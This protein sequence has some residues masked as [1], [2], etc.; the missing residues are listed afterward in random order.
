MKQIRTPSLIVATLALLFSAM[1]AAPAPDMRQWKAGAA[2]VDIT[3]EKPVLMAGY[4]TRTTPSENVMQKLYAKA[5]AM[6]DM[7]GARV[8]WVTLDLIGTPRWLRDEVERKSFEK[9]KLH[10]ESILLN[11]SHTH[12]GPSPKGGRVLGTS[13]DPNNNTEM[14]GEK[15]AQNIVKAIGDALAKLEPATLRYSHARAGFAMNRRAPVGTSF[16]NSPYPDGPV[17]HDVPVLSVTGK[18]GK[19]RALV[20]GYACHNTATGRYNFISADYAG[21]AQEYLQEKRP[22][23]VAL[24]MMGTGGDQNAYPRH[25]PAHELP[26][27]HGRTLAYAV[28]A[29]LSVAEQRQLAGPLRSSYGYATLD[30]VD[31]SKA[32][33]ERRARSKNAAEK[34]RA[35]DL[36][37]QVNAGKEL[38]KTYPCPVQVVQFGNDLTLVAIGG[39]T[40]VDYSLRIKRELGGGKP[41]IW[42]AGYS[43][44]VFG[45]LG[46]KKVIVEG[47][48]EGYSSNMTRHPGP[49]G[50]NTEERIIGKMYELIRMINH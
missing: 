48:Y 20:F 39:E 8:V 14:Y 42:V 9:Y 21:Y 15:L 43:N 7:L 50:S 36:L 30:F 18:D 33:L 10:P 6:E 49:L 16:G 13:T 34:K 35:E 44:D 17:D 47:G 19:L 22:G 45:Y 37:E 3:P 1:Y 11:S 31:T 2:A 4:A 5:V 26:K 12:T 38:A 23:V 46:G 29:A 25:D 41:A 27:H 24:F 40:T 28:E 32:D